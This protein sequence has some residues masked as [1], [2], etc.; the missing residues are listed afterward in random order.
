MKSKAEIEAE[1]APSVVPSTVKQEKKKP[2]EKVSE[3]LKPAKVTAVPQT[4][5]EH[6][7]AAKGGGRQPQPLMSTAMPQR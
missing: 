3:N 4:A 2:K 1:S 7:K 5:A 6:L